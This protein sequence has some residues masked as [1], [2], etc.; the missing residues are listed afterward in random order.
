MDYTFDSKQDSVV[1]AVLQK[2]EN[3]SA[4]SKGAVQP[5]I[6]QASKQVNA[7]VYFQIED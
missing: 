6:T 4:S 3:T 1:K 7:E 5:V 2:T